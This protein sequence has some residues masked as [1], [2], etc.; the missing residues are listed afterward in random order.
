MKDSIT[1][2]TSRPDTLEDYQSPRSYREDPVV[3]ALGVGAVVI[4][5]LWLGAVVSMLAYGMLNQDAPRTREERDLYYLSEV[6]QEAPRS[7][8]A[9]SDYVNAL[10]DAGQYAAA[11]RAIEDGLEVASEKSLILAA[12]ANLTR[13]RGN[14][15]LAL[16]QADAAI[17]AANHEREE[18]LQGLGV[19]NKDLIRLEPKG[20]IPALLLKAG[21][22]VERQDWA[23]AAEAYTEIIELE[24]AAADVLVARGD[25]YMRL[26][27]VDLAEADFRE[28]LRYVPDYQEALDGL[29]AI[30]ASAE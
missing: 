7:A 3:R 22:Y 1:A 29:S 25:A 20:L 5:I 24:P 27:D 21:V 2:S 18:D 17:D 14:A 8:Q 4:L 10:V 9:W 26:G 13:V 15:D 28:A 19:T 23:A 30:G 6:V 12:Q 16:E 11:E